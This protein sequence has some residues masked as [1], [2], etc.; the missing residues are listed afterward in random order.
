M[1]IHQL[2]LGE[3]RVNCY[4]AETAPSRCV[5]V[6][7]GGDPDYLL[8]YLDEKKLTLTKI[9]LTHGHFDHIGGVEAVRKATGAEVYI[10]EFDAKMLTSEIYSLAKGMSFVPFEPVDEWISVYDDCIINDGELS[11]KVIHTPGH[12]EGSVCYICDDVIFSGDTLFCGSVGR[13]DFPGSNPIDMRNS[14]ARLALLDGDYRV[15]PGHN[16]STT[17]ERERRSNP[18]MRDA[19]K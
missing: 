7:L 6:D 12:S 16:S 9:L 5:I 3:L 14:L 4:L 1:K 8:R 11:F 2:N 13:T 18:Y 15:L 19:V 17:L 10:H